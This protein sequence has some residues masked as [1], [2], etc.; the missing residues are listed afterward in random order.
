MNTAK[1]NGGHTK[2]DNAPGHFMAACVEIL[3]QTAGYELVSVAHYGEQ[4]GDLMRDPDIV[5]MANEQN[6]WPI[7]YRNDYVG[8]DHESA[9]FDEAGQL[10][11]Y[12]PRMQ[13]DITACANML[14]RNI[15]DQQGI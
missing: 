13:A 11:G 9:D 6:A 3:G 4:N 12:R 15:A 7:S 2:I 5:I 14:L 1:A 8:I 10:K